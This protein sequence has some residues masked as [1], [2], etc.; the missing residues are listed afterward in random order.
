MPKCCK[1]QS[2]NTV[3]AEVVAM[4]RPNRALGLPEDIQGHWCQKCWDQAMPNYNVIYVPSL[5]SKR[6][7]CRP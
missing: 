4:T 5:I 2:P 3:T 7:A 6:E 1:C